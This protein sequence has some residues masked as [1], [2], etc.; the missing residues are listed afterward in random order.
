MK[1][2]TLYFDHDQA[3]QNRTDS[4]FFSLTTRNLKTPSV[5][6]YRAEDKYWQLPLGTASGF[7]VSMRKPDQ[8]TSVHKMADTSE[9]S[10]TFCLK[11]YGRR[12]VLARAF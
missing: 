2:N 12:G 3:E 4:F 5:C 6:N 11:K 10:E 8:T 1:P 9:Q 7:G